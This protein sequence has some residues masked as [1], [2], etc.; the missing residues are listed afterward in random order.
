MVDYMEDVIRSVRWYMNP[1]NHQAAVALVAAFNKQKPEGIDWLFT[2]Q[3]TYRNLNGEPNLDAIQS[4]LNSMNELG[5]L[6]AKIDVHKHAD[7]SIA[8]EAAARFK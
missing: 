5:F 3:D 2:K 4:N 1:A 6:P 8:R 7:L